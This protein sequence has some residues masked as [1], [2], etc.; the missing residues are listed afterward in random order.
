MWR[1]KTFSPSDRRAA[2]ALFALSVG[3]AA[4]SVEVL[5]VGYVLGQV[6][7]DSGLQTAIAV[8][9]YVG[10]ALGGIVSGAA[11]DHLGRVGVLRV[12]IMVGAMA[13]VAIA[14][15]PNIAV[16]ISCRWISGFCVGAMWPE[17][18]QSTPIPV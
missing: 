12:A 18:S 9:V 3:N 6:T 8:S 15:A 14:F 5:S 13:T 7:T 1:R 4:E 16:L 10:M 17:C 11:S 2:C